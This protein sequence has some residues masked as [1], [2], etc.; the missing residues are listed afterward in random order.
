MYIY[1]LNIYLC[2]Y[3]YICCG[4]PGL[5][6]FR[7]SIS[8]VTLRFCYTQGAS[9]GLQNL[10]RRRMRILRF[11]VQCRNLIKKPWVFI[12]VLSMDPTI[13]GLL[14]Q[15]FLLRFLLCMHM[16]IQQTDIHTYIH[17]CIHANSF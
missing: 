5:W 16:C 4:L 11:G 10:A 8:L 13:L 1:I 15:C 14:S 2:V 7:L 9:S 6:G 12:W 3:I 17:A